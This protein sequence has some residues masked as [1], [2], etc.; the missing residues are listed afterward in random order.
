[1]RRR[2]VEEEEEAEDVGVHGGSGSS[3]GRL[4]LRG[5]TP[6]RAAPL[7]SSFS[8]STCSSGGTVQNGRGS[9]PGAVRVWLSAGAAAALK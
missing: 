6:P 9:S 7:P 5:D 1:V 2:G 4:R 8:S 3:L